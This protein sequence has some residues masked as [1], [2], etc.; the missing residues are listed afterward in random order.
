M[1][2]TA[3]EG[4][5]DVNDVKQPRKGRWWLWLGGALLLVL[6]AVASL[7]LWAGGV[8]VGFAEKTFADRA[9]R[10]EVGA[11]DL[12]WTGRQAA[13]EV[14]LYDPEGALVAEVSAEL[15]SLLALASGL[16]KRIGTV[17]ITA[18]AD[19]VA[20]DSG[21]TNLERALAPRAPEEPKEE[22]PG[23]GSGGGGLEGLD[24]EVQLT[25]PRLSWSDARTRALGEPFV[26]LGSQRQRRR[27]TRRAPGARRR[28]HAPGRGQAP[29]ARQRDRNHGCVRG[30]PRARSRPRSAA[31]RRGSSMP[32]PASTACSWR[33]SGPPSSSRPTRAAASRRA[34]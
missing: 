21:R 30:R 34:T 27:A 2:L 28:R 26:R 20:D 33:R 8:A 17:S 19:L 12:S 3:R 31:C 23:G 14:K 7:P 1:G 5:P 10:L 29:R 16:G 15:P 11:L 32:W 4:N 13:R 6:I 22:K 9:G 24:V 18:S 25:C